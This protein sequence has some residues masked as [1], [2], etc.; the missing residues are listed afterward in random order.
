MRM[1]VMGFWI[2]YE[3]MWWLIYAMQ[4]TLPVGGVVLCSFSGKLSREE[5]IG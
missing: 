2:L 5:W 4:Y 1:E 3:Y